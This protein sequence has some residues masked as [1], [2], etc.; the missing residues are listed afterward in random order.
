MRPSKKT[1]LYTAYIIGITIL[2]LWYLFPSDTL[3][4]YLAYRLTQGS[5][6]VSVTIDRVSPILPPGIKL[7]GV[8]V[9]RRSMTLIGLESI[10]IMPELQSLLSDKTAVRFKGRAY[11]G[12]LS[13]RV[14]LGDGSQGNGLKID[15][16]I[17]GVQMQQISVLKQLS[18]HEISGSLDGNFTYADAGANPLLA[19]NL[20]LTNCRIMLAAPLFSQKSFD[21]KDIE[22]DL[23]MQNNSLIIKQLNAKGNQLDL[24]LAGNI[25]LN[26]SDPAKNRLNLTGTVTPHHVFLAKIENDIP[27]DFLRNKKAGKTAI[28]FKVDGTMDE[29]GFSLN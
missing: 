6:D 8:V 4:A 12:S 11:A 7:K 18:E 15:G 17:A 2:F 13:G 20:T 5:S 19:G 24:I 10:N 14:E 9:G 29:P 25:D 23:T 28:S 27:V 26:T 16:R 3:K 22:A 1:I 21:F